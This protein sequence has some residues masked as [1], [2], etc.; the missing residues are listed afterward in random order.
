MPKDKNLWIFGEWLGKTYRDNSKYLFEYALRQSSAPRCVWITRNAKIQM[1]LRAKGIEAYHPNSLRGVFL[2]M[3]AH[4]AVISVDILD[5]HK[6]LLAPKRLVQLYHGSPLKRISADDEKRHRPWRSVLKRLLLTRKYNQYDIQLSAAPAVSECLRT[7]Y[8]NT[9]QIVE[10]GYPRSDVLK[11]TREPLNSITYLP[12]HRN[13]GKAQENFL[14]RS[15]R[16]SEIDSWL[17]RRGMKLKIK[18]HPF[19]IGCNLSLDECQNITLV[20]PGEDAYQLLQETAI[21]ITDY[22]SIYLDFLLTKRPIIFS[23]F[24][25]DDYLRSDRTLYFR[26]EDVTPGPR[27]EDWPSILEELEKICAG[28][29]T[30]KGRRREVCNRFN[31]HQDFQ[32][33]RRV[34][35]FLLQSA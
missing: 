7:A 23:P 28:V 8:P 30:Y 1:E 35:E 26:Y 15:F 18:L 9:K 13:F 3:R 2:I 29:D 4:T 10:L 16:E 6:G 25:I 24:D 20:D 33:S 34:Y 22:S 11:K 17:N 14:F 27:C 31:T 32:S 12:T 19:S 5:I 21:L